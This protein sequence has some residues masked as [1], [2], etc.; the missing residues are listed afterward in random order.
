MLKMHIIY[1]KN[2]AGDIIAVKTWTGDKN[3]GINYVKFDLNNKN[4]TYNRVWAE[5][6][7]SK[8]KE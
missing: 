7:N 2:S 6:V 3:E 8:V 5:E 4:V 1:A